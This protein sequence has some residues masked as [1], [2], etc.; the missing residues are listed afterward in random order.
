VL[1]GKG[2]VAPRQKIGAPLPACAPFQLAG[3]RD[4]GSGGNTI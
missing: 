3:Y 4:G 2:S 1:A